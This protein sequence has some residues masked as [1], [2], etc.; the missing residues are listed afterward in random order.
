[1]AHKTRFTDLAYRLLAREYGM[2]F[3]FLEMV[4]AEALVRRNAGTEELMKTVP[5]DKP[6]GAMTGT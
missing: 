3:C 4:S 6:L 1:M 2:E 5:A